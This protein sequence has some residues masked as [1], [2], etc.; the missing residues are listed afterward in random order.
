MTPDNTRPA[1]R[2]ILYILALLR[3]FGSHVPDRNVA[4]SELTMSRPLSAPQLLESLI[5]I[6][7]L[8][9]DHTP[10]APTSEASIPAEISTCS[11]E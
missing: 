1:A 8:L 9:A 11:H 10:Y 6:L 4:R 3:L 2:Q 5:K 7:I